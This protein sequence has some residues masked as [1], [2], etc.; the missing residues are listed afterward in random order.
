MSRYDDEFFFF[1][2]EDRLGRLHIDKDV[3]ILMLW[4]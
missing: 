3:S 1:G 2:L 4:P